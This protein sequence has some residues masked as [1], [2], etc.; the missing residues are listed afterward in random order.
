M[1][2]IGN[3]NSEL[4]TF[5]FYL[6]V[7]FMHFDLTGQKLTISILFLILFII[8][9]FKASFSSYSPFVFLLLAI[10]FPL[11]NLILISDIQ[12][13]FFDFIKTYILYILSAIFHLIAIYSPFKSKYFQFDKTIKIS[14]LLI[15]I[16][17]SIQFI[18]AFLFK[19]PILFNFF[20]KFQYSNLVNI[21]HLTSGFLPRTQGFYLE[22]SYLAFVVITLIAMSINLKKDVG[23]IFL[24][25]GVTILMSGSRGGFIGFFLLLA[26]HQY[27]N[28]KLF[29]LKFY[30]LLFLLFA[31]LLAFVLPVISLLKAE[32]LLTEN[33]SQNVRFY[34]GFT[35]CYFILKNYFSGIPIGSL[36][37]AFLLA[38]GE[39]SSIFS[40]YI[41]NIIYHGWFSFI[42]IFIIYFKLFFSKIHNN[43]RILLFIYILLYFNM[44]GSIL[45]PDTY[46]WFFCFYY[47]YRI[48]KLPLSK[49]S[50]A[51][52]VI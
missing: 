7:I 49:F 38:N 8:S 29:T 40:F 5:L 44:T 31:I 18:S 41:F 16:I 17:V 14:I 51:S 47:T 37:K 6:S 45:A 21:E 30:L 34:Q 28:L 22:P 15:F 26:Y 4:F 13:S 24:L 3:N 25:G 20:G 23:L 11:T 46:F 36:S 50:N 52:I 42:L 10:L 19:K 35:L 33:S 27:N 43:S 32:S 2:L 9:Y 1:K 39:D 12:P 48:S